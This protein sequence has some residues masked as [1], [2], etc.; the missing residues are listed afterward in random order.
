MTRSTPGK[1]APD[2]EEGQLIA[3]FEMMDVDGSGTVCYKEFA[4]AWAE[5]LEEGEHASP[6]AL[7]KVFD[8]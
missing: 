8:A 1:P 5:E 6:D 3:L 2:L 4:D 7:A